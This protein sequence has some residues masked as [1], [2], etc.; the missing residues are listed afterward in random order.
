MEQAKKQTV[1]HYWYGPDAVL[2]W[3]DDDRECKHTLR[4]ATEA[5]PLEASTDMRAICKDIARAGSGVV[6][7]ELQ[8]EYINYE[9][10]PMEAPDVAED[11]GPPVVCAPLLPRTVEPPVMSDDEDVTILL[12][13]SLKASRNMYV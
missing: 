4:R 12:P 13:Q 5:Q 3:C 11:G 1:P 10:E 2:D 6:A 7:P 9:F 8:R